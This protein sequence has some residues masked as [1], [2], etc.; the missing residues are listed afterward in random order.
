VY[1]KCSAPGRAGIIGNPTDMYGGSVISCS[2]VERANVWLVESD[3]MV[4]DIEGKKLVIKDKRDLAIDRTPFDIAKAVVEFLQLEDAKF[5]LICRT[6]IPKQAGLSGSTAL[7]VAIM[8][9]LLAFKGE[10]Y[11]RYKLAEMARHI[12][13]NFMKVVCGYQDAYMCTFGGLNYMDFRAK[14]FYRRWAREPYATIEPL[15]DYVDEFPFVVAHTGIEHFSGSVHKPIRDRWL[16]GEREVV[17]GYLRVA[18][19]ARLGKKALLEKDWEVLGELM[20]E[21]HEIQRN[22]GGSGEKNEELIAVA[23]KCGAYGAKLAGG[24]RGGTIIALH[25]EP[26]E[27][28]EELRKAGA[29]DILFPMPMEGVKV[30]VFEGELKEEEIPDPAPQ[31]R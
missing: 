23:L 2:T 24:G 8:N 12:E 26:E 4:F 1:I 13:L 18:H 17:Q 14:E 10:S 6:N 5:K 9:A 29:T 16:E 20:N 25:L 11:N 15:T 31:K 19:L 21:N 22:L 28:I 7:I 30:E 27:M 3:E